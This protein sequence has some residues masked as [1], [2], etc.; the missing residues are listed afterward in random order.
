[1]GGDLRLGYQLTDY[2]KT[3]LTYRCDQIKIS[4]ISSNATIDLMQEQGKNTI[5]SIMPSAV[6][7]TRDNVFDPHKGDL[8]TSSVE[9]AGGPLSGN[10]DYWKYY[11]S[12]SHYVP[13][14]WNS[15]LEIKGR[16][17]VGA[18]YDDTAR[19]PIYERFFAGGAYTIRGYEERKVGPIDPVSRDPLG[20]D[21][22]LIG[23][24]EYTYPLFSFLKLAAFYDVG[25]VWEKK[26][27]FGKDG[28]KSGIGFGVRVKTPL[29][30]IKL[31]YG[32]P[33]N[34]EPGDD[35]IKGGRLHFSASH[36]F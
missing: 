17:G 12:A 6:F 7:D 21:A 31:D 25:N 35:E 34:K 14:A 1:L 26:K 27:D 24:L 29:G 33:M 8:L 13:L 11:G 18:P 23:N 15:V 5:S 16:A 30:P 20:G 9:F 28:Y 10:K 32:F 22:M 4:N 3:D 19:I 36:D 2:I